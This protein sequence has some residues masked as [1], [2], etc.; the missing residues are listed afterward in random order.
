MTYEFLLDG[1][2]DD[3]ESEREVTA[4]VPPAEVVHEADAVGS[5]RFPPV[6]PSPS[7][8]PASL[9]D[10]PRD[11]RN[12]RKIDHQD[13]ALKA[14]YT[15]HIPICFLQDGRLAAGPK[16]LLVYLTRSVN[17]KANEVRPSQATL[18]AELKTNKRT[19]N[20]SMQRLKSLGYVVVAERGQ[21]AGQANV[22]ELSWKPS[23]DVKGEDIDGV[24][25][26][27]AVVPAYDSADVPGYD[28][29]GALETKRTETKNNTPAAVAVDARSDDHRLQTGAD[30]AVSSPHGRA[31]APMRELAG[32]PAHFPPHR[33]DP[34]HNIIISQPLPD[35]KEL[36]N[37]VLNPLHI[38][39][40]LRSHYKNIC[41][42]L[43]TNVPQLLVTENVKTI[44][45]VLD[46]VSRMLETGLVD[47]RGPVGILLSKVKAACT[48]P[49]RDFELD[50]AQRAYDEAQRPLPDDQW[51]EFHARIERQCSI[52]ARSVEEWH[53]PDVAAQCSGSDMYPVLLWCLIQ[54][55]GGQSAPVY[56][57]QAADG[58]LFSD[59]RTREFYR[60]AFP[61]VDTSQLE[62]YRHKALLQNH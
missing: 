60:Q 57:Q 16:L 44:Q 59:E 29:D 35:T 31:A 48:I 49:E 6:V 10:L 37:A 50:D 58:W 20:R 7:D 27:A 47:Q 12:R 19:I 4:E 42:A 13:Q 22:Y 40:P 46:E 26:D 23:L 62:A 24:G 5:K 8:V 28:A 54:K 41:A 14:G 21:E 34:D 3:V 9:C 55:H 15:M 52:Y 56:A 17:M 32:E 39:Q 45:E 11:G 2:S 43:I 25:H 18:A 51:E 38:P 30:G 61:E 33:N 36:V 1:G 53:D